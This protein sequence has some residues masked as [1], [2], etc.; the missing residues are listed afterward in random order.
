[1]NVRGFVYSLLLVAPMSFAATLPSD[2]K[3]NVD[4]EIIAT[5]IV[6]N[7]NEISAADLAPSKTSNKEVGEYAR[8]MKKEHSK[9]LKQTMSISKKQNLGMHLT[10]QSIKISVF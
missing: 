1:M 5:L 8:L 9:N 4:Q 6:L 10:P 3:S 2:T 7:N